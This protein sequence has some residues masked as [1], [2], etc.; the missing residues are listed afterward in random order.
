MLFFIEFFL[1]SNF[2]KG[3]VDWCFFINEG[4]YNGCKDYGWVVVFDGEEELC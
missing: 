4:Y 1:Y 3:V 2:G